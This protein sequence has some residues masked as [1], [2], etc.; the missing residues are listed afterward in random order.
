MID[1]ANKQHLL[2]FI[3]DDTIH[4]TLC[5]EIS[6]VLFAVLQ[7]IEKDFGRETQK[8][9]YKCL[10]SEIR[11]SVGK[12]FTGK[13]TRIVNALNGISS[14]VQIGMSDVDFILSVIKNARQELREEYTLERHVEMVR[15]RLQAE[16]F[17]EQ[18]IQEWIDHI[19]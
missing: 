7:I 9:I 17:S 12:C 2:E 19:E 6:D 8:E 18:V 15:E 13:I 14:L 10:E 4:S 16:N 3:C 11:D 1:A 5:V